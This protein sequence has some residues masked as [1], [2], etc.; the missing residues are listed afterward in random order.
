M[1]NDENKN[2]K[3]ITEVDYKKSFES[4][5]DFYL[6]EKDTLKK[7]E[8]KH[9]D[10]IIKRISEK[11]KKTILD[12]YVKS[13]LKCEKKLIV[14]EEIKKVFD[15]L[16]DN[17][18]LNKINDDDN[19]RS[20]LEDDGDDQNKK[21]CINAIYISKQIIDDDD[22]KIH[23]YAVYLFNKD[24]VSQIE[25]GQNKKINED[26]INY[27]NYEPNIEEINK[28]LNDIFD[29]L[30]IEP[31]NYENDDKINVDTLN[32]N[33]QNSNLSNKIKEQ[34]SDKN[35]CLYDDDKYKN[36][37]S[38]KYYDIIFDI[39]SLDG[40]KENGWIFQI[41]QDSLDKY[42]K[43]KNLR[44]TVVSVIGN[45]NKGKSFILSKIG[46]KDIPTGHNITTKGLSAIYPD[47]E[48]KNIILLDTAGFE[49]PLCEDEKIF[50]FKT[51]NE[52][53]NNKKNKNDKAEIKDFLSR[54]EYLEQITKFI[55]DRL[56]TDNFLQ[57]F[58]M[59]S[60]D[61]LLCIVNE[62][63][64]SDQKFLNKIQEENK[65]KKIYI[66]H[67]LKTIKET[68]KVE[69]YIEEKLLRVLTFRLQK[70]LY[71]T[72]DNEDKEYYETRNKEYYKQVFLNN[73]DKNREV[74]HLF[75]ANEGSE[76]GKYYNESTINFLTTQ[77][78]SY[79]NNE[80][81]PIIEK[82]K[83]FLFKN[84]DIFFNNSLED[85]KDIQ[86]IVDDDDNKLKYVNKEKDYKLKECYED[87][88][89]N[90]NFIQSDYK[91][92]YRAYIVDYKDDKGESK[93]FILDIEISGKI[94]NDMLKIEKV[95]KGNESIITITGQKKKKQNEQKYQKTISE[96]KSHY[97][98][99][100]LKNFN[101]R[102]YIPSEYCIV[103]NL[104]KKKLFID[105]GLYR[106]IFD[107]IKTNE[108]VEEM[109]ADI[110][111]EDDENEED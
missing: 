59:D 69:E 13:L 46:K 1:G 15:Y 19:K 40:L 37:S 9:K 104:Y 80:S 42:D 2:F 14:L 97:F 22:F 10:D 92:Y 24:E 105:E 16:K 77:I 94:D 39:D 99:N 73:N 34:N 26:F 21:N 84:S 71:T 27:Q 82:V 30:K 67:N 52:E 53:Y 29:E 51:V 93:K 11:Q 68:K 76:A 96:Y 58:I 64:L 5:K 41:S 54:D 44:N 109:D 74:I 48:N 33:N 78:L 61:I 81:F 47:Y 100:E 50:K 65:D 72:I 25:N 17:F 55:R 90:T 87:E 6:S 31:K 95:I 8:K 111:D 75:M 66:I 85:E 108:E 20:L 36:E 57:K 49:V 88:L 18:E 23:D 63:N 38:L 91:P 12:E 45:K 106:Y 89:G 28:K 56:N 3:E 35:N 60:A 32:K 83:K 7:N 62:L 102:I 79:T 98:T 103:G 107:V 86:E 101:L 70:G 43:K 4:F 110:V